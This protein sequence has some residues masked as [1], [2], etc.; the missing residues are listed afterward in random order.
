M[1]IVILMWLHIPGLLDRAAD[2]DVGAI[3][4]LGVL[5]ISSIGVAVKSS[6]QQSI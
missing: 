4:I 3:A 1:K 2:G 5:G 6:V